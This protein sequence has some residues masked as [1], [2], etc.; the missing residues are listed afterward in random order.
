M[1]ITIFL[2]REKKGTGLKRAIKNRMNPIETD[3]DVK[4]AWVSALSDEQVKH[5]VHTASWEEERASYG[6]DA[7]NKMTIA[8]SEWKSVVAEKVDRIYTEAF[9]NKSKN[10]IKKTLSYMLQLKNN[11]AL[12]GIKKASGQFLKSKVIS[13]IT[14]PCWRHHIANFW[15]MVATGY[16]F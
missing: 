9:R 14:G 8:R 3:A 4:R 12:N 16:G 6:S 15:G 11:S 10:G 1:Q 2:E 13:F 7:E 5:L